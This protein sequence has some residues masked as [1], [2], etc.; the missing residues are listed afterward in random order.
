MEEDR[1]QAMATRLRRSAER[2]GI[3]GTA[4]GDL[5]VA[6]EKIVRLRSAA[7]PD[8]G[9]QALL[10]PART[11]LI[12]LEDLTVIDVAMLC[13]G[14]WYDSLRADLCL[15]AVEARS[16]S[17]EGAAALLASL[18]PDGLEDAELLEQLV[19]ADSRVL[20]IALAE[21]LDHARHLHLMPREEWTDFHRQ[22]R[23]IHLP[24]AQR[25]HPRL[26][27]RYDWWTATFA[28]RFLENPTS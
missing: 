12:L 18:P 2:A 22:V 6:Y 13:A 7:F 27:R 14:L 4:I 1:A 10:H 16:L 8:P 9:E 11:A 23:D 3:D 21:R 24:L 28:R 17:P 20:L 25:A 5:S 26:A 19:V 15:P